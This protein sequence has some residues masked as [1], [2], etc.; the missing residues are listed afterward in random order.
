MQGT[1]HKVKYS[2]VIANLQ[3]SPPP[4]LLTAALC[5]V[6]IILAIYDLTY[7]ETAIVNEGTPLIICILV[8]ISYLSTAFLL[9]FHQPLC[10]LTL[11]L[12]LVL[13]HFPVLQDEYW[14]V[15]SLTLTVL[16]VYSMSAWF[17]LPT[18]VFLLYYDSYGRY[19]SPQIAPSVRAGYIVFD[20]GCF[21]LLPILVRITIERVMI[22][23]RVEYEQRLEAAYQAAGEE[24]KNLARELHDVV[25]HELTV[26]AMQAR[27]ARYHDSDGKDQVLSLIG[28][29]SRQALKELRR[30]LAV[31]RVDKDSK[32]LN[33]E[34][35]SMGIDLEKIV[36]RQCKQLADLG[37]IVE[38]TIT[39]D[40]ENVPKSFTPTVSRVVSESVTNVIKHGKTGGVVQLVL[41]VDNNAIHYSLINEI[42]QGKDHLQFPS[43]GF[44]LMGLMERVKPLGGQLTSQREGNRWAMRVTLPITE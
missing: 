29:Q 24:R 13:L 2:R 9:H 41:L 32:M 1:S 23:Q 35:Q 37:Y 7:I 3:F 40:F 18:I 4:Q 5:V 12:L 26:I 10:I 31:M 21:V 6:L 14:R 11:W 30:L 25:A 16:V 36:R 38:P 34:H 20:I 42:G 39:G 33:P 43:S 44:G 17:W 8:P 19:Q 27:T 22:H 15:T 28:D